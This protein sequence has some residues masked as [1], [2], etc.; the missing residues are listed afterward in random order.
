M[1]NITDRILG[2]V[3]ILFKWVAILMIGY[4]IIMMLFNG[5]SAQK[6]SANELKEANQKIDE[7]ENE[8]ASKRDVDQYTEEIAKTLFD[9]LSDNFFTQAY[10]DRLAEIYSDY[11]ED[12][13]QRR[14]LAGKAKQ[15]YQKQLK[16]Y[17]SGLFGYSDEEAAEILGYTDDDIQRMLD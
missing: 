12:T 8:L 6:Q 11:G 13:T 5:C 7:L 15:E 4:F 3:L 9:D 14:V 17:L 1:K 10:Y 2:I 16:D